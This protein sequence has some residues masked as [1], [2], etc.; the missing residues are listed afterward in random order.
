MR[1]R[2]LGIM[3]VVAVTPLVIAAGGSVEGTDTVAD[4]QP[5]GTGAGGDQSDLLIEA[6][7]NDPQ[8]L[9][10]DPI[11][12]PAYASEIVNVD[13]SEYRIEGTPRVAFAIQAPEFSWP[14]TYNDAVEARQAEAYPDIDLIISPTGLGRPT[15]RWPRSRT[16][17]CSSPM[18]SS[19]PRSPMS[20]ARW[21]RRPPR[22]SP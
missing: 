9:G 8:Q 2:G 19:S 16:C 21:S 11:E 20:G 15:P 3:A 10:L 18:R 6:F 4:T 22:A 7:E 13:T 14:A 17:W 1:R 12:P 5:P